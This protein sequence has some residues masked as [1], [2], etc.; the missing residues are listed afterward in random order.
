M[1][2]STSKI[3]FPGSGIAALASSDNNIKDILKHLNIQTIGYDKVNQLRENLLL[4]IDKEI[5]NSNKYFRNNLPNKLS[6][7]KKQTQYLD[8]VYVNCD[9][10]FYHLTGPILLKI[11]HSKGFIDGQINILRNG[12]NEE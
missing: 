10:E 8:K 7:N 4:F 9:G 2:F 3:S 1:F 12:G 6:P 5:R 11:S